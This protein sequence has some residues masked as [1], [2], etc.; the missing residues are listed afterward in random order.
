MRME[1]Q[2]LA[3]LRGLRIRRYHELLRRSQT[4]LGSG[5]AVAVAKA[6]SNS[7]PSLGTSMCRE[8]GPKKNME[9]VFPLS[10]AFFKKTNLNN[11]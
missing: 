1:V 11:E 4:R 10:F 9:H 5:V 8:S 6:S 3:L 2:S 7:T